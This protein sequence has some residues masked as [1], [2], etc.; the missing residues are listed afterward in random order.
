MSDTVILGDCL[1]ELPKL[2]DACADIILTDPPYLTTNLKLDKE[3]ADLDMNRAYREMGR[4]LKPNGWFF[5]FGT[6]EMAAGILQHFRFKFDYVWAKQIPTMQRANTVRPLKRHE[7][8]FAFIQPS[9]KRMS[10]L[11]FDKAAL[12]THGHKPYYNNQVW[13]KAREYEQSLGMKTGVRPVDDNPG[14]REGISILYA[15]NKTHMPKAER[16]THPTQKPVDL[17][18]YIIKGY[19]PEDGLVID[20]FAGSGSTCVAA[21][22]NNRRY[23][24][25]EI[26][27]EYHTMAKGRLNGMLTVPA[28]Y[29]KQ[30]VVQ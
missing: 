4:I 20:P 15:N 17:L 6:I 7:H 30:K 18:S 13:K 22:Q 19:C 25:I 23:V 2:P 5:T 24:G 14:Y 21:H 27:P 16:T 12:R 1:A 11:Y 8:V 9:L 10:D 26:N 28:Q 29:A 3:S